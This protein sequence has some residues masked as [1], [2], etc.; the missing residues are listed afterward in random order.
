MYIGINKLSYHYKRFF[1]DNKLTVQK[2]LFKVSDIHGIKTERF[3][4]YF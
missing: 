3:A 4:P 1:Y 2:Y